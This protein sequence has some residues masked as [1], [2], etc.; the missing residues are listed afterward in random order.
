MNTAGKTRR[1][2]TVLHP[3]IGA[4]IAGTY[5]FAT[6]EQARQQL[7][8]FRDNFVLSKHQGAA[9]HENNILLWIKGYMVNSSEKSNGWTGNYCAIGIVKRADGKFTLEGRKV[10]SDLKYHPQRQR[11]KHKHPNWGHPILRSVKKK[12]IYQTVEA[13]QAELQQLHEEYPEVTIPLTNK[14]YLI[15][16]SRQQNPPAQKFVLELKVD[17]EGGFYID[18]YPNDYK[19]AG[20]ETLSESLEQAG[21]DEGLQEASEEKRKPGEDTGYFTS[22][23]ALKRARK[24]NSRP[25]INIRPQ[26][27]DDP[28]E[29]ADADAES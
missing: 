5:R 21:D 25:K 8:I 15:I 13:A 2:A 20:A 17:D 12:R 28:V 7:G 18:S 10:E 29:D 23:V 11:P 14:L 27:K 16:Y 24:K 22:M 4:V 6:E 3:T 26:Q 1:Y 19:G 9:E